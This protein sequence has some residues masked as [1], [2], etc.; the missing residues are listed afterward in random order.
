ME[1][2]NSGAPDQ[3]PHSAASGL[4]LHC[5]PM[6]DKKKASKAY[7]DYFI[8][9]GLSLTINLANILTTL[10]NLKTEISIIVFIFSIYN[11]IGEPLATYTINSLCVGKQFIMFCCLSI[12]FSKIAF[13]RNNFSN[14]IRASNNFGS[15]SGPTFC[16]A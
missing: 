12:F 9:P 4:D 11:L 6:S 2:A 16:W 10:G 7:M 15:R 8:E 13:S 3:I 5:L 1:N 14:A